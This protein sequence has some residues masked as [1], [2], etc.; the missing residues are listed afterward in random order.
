MYVCTTV[1]FTYP[2]PDVHGHVQA[3]CEAHGLRQCIEE[4]ASE[5]PQN[6][7]HALDQ[8]GATYV[9]VCY[10]YT[11]LYIRCGVY[12]MYVVDGEPGV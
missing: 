10:V 8:L 9:C 6:E 5:H 3:L 7:H 2:H 11:E 1:S 4:R 12:V